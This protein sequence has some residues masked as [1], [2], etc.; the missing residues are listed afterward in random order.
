MEQKG[1]GAIMDY[2]R[3]LFLFLW[4]V[5]FVGWIACFAL[6]IAKRKETITEKRKILYLMCMFSVLM[7]IFSFLK[8]GVTQC[9]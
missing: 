6:Y 3:C 4:V 7:I 8:D 2:L 5:S 9:M 1:G